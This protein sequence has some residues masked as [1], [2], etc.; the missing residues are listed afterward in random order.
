IMDEY[1]D[2]E[3][4]EYRRT[5]ERF[6]S[7]STAWH[8]DKPDFEELRDEPFMSFDEFVRYR[9]RTSAALGRAYEAMMQE[10]RAVAIDLKGDVKAAVG[11]DIEWTS[12]SGYEQWVVQLFHKD[13]M[14][15]FGG[16]GIV[17]EGLLPKRLMTM[18]RQSRFQWQG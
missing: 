5:K 1:R 17:D 11:G 9:E 15:R 3:E 6:E 12:R 13:M 2:K 8:Q 16:L 14:A 18:L 4:F 7:P 10:P